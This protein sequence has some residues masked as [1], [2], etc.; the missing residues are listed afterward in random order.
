MLTAPPS[1]AYVTPSLQN[2]SC[3]GTW[4]FDLYKLEWA[5]PSTD[6][7]YVDCYADTKD[8]RVM[9]DMLTLDGMTP[10]VCRAHCEGKGNSYYATQVNPHEGTTTA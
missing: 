3:G 6:P 8:D 5:S 9:D 4:A 10:S 2:E 1:H 7:E